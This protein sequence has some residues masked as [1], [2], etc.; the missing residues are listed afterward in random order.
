MHERE[1]PSVTSAFAPSDRPTC[2]RDASR[3][4]AR[5]HLRRRSP[6]SLPPRFVHTALSPSPRVLRL[7]S[8]LSFPNASALHSEPKIMHANPAYVNNKN[9]HPTALRHR[10]SPCGH[11]SRYIALDAP[12]APRSCKTCRNGSALTNGTLATVNT[13]GP[14]RSQNVP[15]TSR[16]F[17]F[18]CVKIA[19]T[20]LALAF[21]VSDA[22]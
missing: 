2:A 15:S 3:R 8:R 18:L 9:V 16:Y 1:E 22:R 10:T 6:R 14:R 11:P 7:H 19:I 13:V 4:C 17:A 21:T 5:A 20:P 12:H